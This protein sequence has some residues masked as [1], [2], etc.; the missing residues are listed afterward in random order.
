[1]NAL[2]AR[3]ATPVLGRLMRPLAATL[4]LLALAAAAL[5]W[6]QQEQ[7]MREGVAQR[8]AEVSERLEIVQTQQVQVMSA[9]LEVI[10]ANSAMHEALRARDRERLLAEHREIFAAMQHEYGISHFYFHDAGRGNV[11]RLHYP[12]K[13]AGHVDRYLVR[14]AERTGATVGG[15]EFGTF[16]LLT[17]RVVRPVLADGEL[18]GFVELGRGIEDI[19]RGLRSGDTADIA[20][21]I[22]KDVVTHTALESGMGLLGQT[23]DWDRY[24]E[25]VLT[26]SSLSPVP[27]GLLDV[28]M[29]NHGSHADESLDLQA[30]AGGRSWRVAFMP[31]SDAAGRDVGDVIIML[32]I[33]AKQAAFLHTAGAAAVLGG[34][35]LLLLLVFLYRLLRK[36]DRQ[37]LAQQTALH[38]SETLQRAIFET[39]VDGIVVIDERGR[40]EL[41]NPAA[42][43]IFGYRPDEVLG[44][45]VSLLMPDPHRAAHDGYLQRYLAGGKAKIIGVGREVQGRRKD[46]SLFPL[47]LAIS[48]TRVGGRRMFSGV[49]RDIT[50]RKQAERE[51]IETREAAERASRA[52][53]E[54]LSRMSHELRTPMNAI[55]GFGQILEEDPGLDAHQRDGVQE[56]LT[57]G[58]H[59]LTLI[60]EVLDL[61]RVEA[62]RLTVVTEPVA[63]RPMIESCLASLRPLAAGRGIAL[64][65]AI[66]GDS[67]VTADPLRL[68]QV[69]FNLLS[70][71]IKYNREAGSVRVTCRLASADRVRLEVA[72]D[73]PGIEATEMPRL[74]QAFERLES[75]CS[76]IE[77]AGIG[78]ALSKRL[79]EAMHGAI[80]VDSIPGTGSIFW[81]ELPRSRQVPAAAA[82]RSEVP[83]SATCTA[84]TAQT[85]LCVE[86]NPANLRLI[87]R[88]L[89]GCPGLTLLDAQTAEQ[90]LE[91]ARRH[92]PDLIL[93]DIGLPGMDGFAA[94]DMLRADPEFRDIPVIA[95]SANAMQRD[96]E[97][98]RAAGFAD[99]LTKPIDVTSF[100][101]AIDRWLGRAPRQECVSGDA[102]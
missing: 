57:S 11:V 48:E 97:R 32:D 67:V 54:F 72:D 73:G 6:H 36:T 77:G 10:T 1:M 74:F 35:V 53:S 70:N 45:N 92:R 33:T 28:H 102:R 60:N 34:G 88:I 26:Y 47:D 94:M 21:A 98:G 9:L 64:E 5:L 38:R 44:K 8:L 95:L 56:I 78:L 84:Q 16:G 90:G 59:L 76:G 37:L 93:M 15:L 29:H 79:V 22:H 24:P 30:T 43:A 19:V 4:A 89:A 49:V 31:L 80:G 91:L 66:A 23:M 81:I 75:G 51:L 12:Q 20:I 17:L 58:R 62:G 61:A 55:L 100:H 86:D 63:C 101:A 18:I 2:S 42:Q 71:A 83:A 25:D 69:L 39:V 52:K 85:L 82:A 46:G 96:I 87:R 3:P 99:Y 50:V 65:A 68:R 40:I 7:R 27:E 41:F 14:E 13:T